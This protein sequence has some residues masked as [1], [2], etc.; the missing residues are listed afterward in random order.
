MPSEL[1][2]AWSSI[3][4]RDWDDTPEAYVSAGLVGWG[5]S[6]RLARVDDPALALRAYLGV[7]HFDP[8]MWNLTGEATATFFLSIRV[9][10]QTL[11]LRIFPTMRDTLAALHA[12]HE[13]MTSNL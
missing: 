12:A 3:Y 2:F 10:G 6:R 7:R 13:E 8:S 9:Q 1:A 11:W 4:H 5:R